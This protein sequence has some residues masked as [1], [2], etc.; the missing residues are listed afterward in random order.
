M[1]IKVTMKDPDTMHDAVREAVEQEV[2]A[3]GL[4]AD[5]EESLIEMRC[6]KEGNKLAKW[7]K[8]SEYLTA[9]FDTDAMTATVLAAS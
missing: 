6:E 3:M 2:K 7:F 4:P 1:K 8:Y 9:E 5:E